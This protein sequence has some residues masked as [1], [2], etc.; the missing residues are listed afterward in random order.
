MIDVH[1]GEL[2]HRRDRGG[3]ARL[4]ALEGDLVLAQAGVLLP[5]LG[6]LGG[7]GE[8]VGLIDLA[9]GLPVVGGGKG[10]PVVARDGEADRLL[11]ARRDV[12]QDQRV[13]GVPADPVLHARPAPGVQSVKNIVR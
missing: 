2:L 7:Q 8:P 1:A 12:N 5:E 4:V 9:L 6:L 11:A 3:A 13:G 10:N